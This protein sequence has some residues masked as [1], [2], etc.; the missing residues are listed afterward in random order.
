MSSDKDFNRGYSGNILHGSNYAERMGV[1]ERSLQNDRLKQEL[2]A[3]QQVFTPPA[4]PSSFNAGSSWTSARHSNYQKP[5]A[6]RQSSG[7]SWAPLG[8]IGLWV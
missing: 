3:R 6:S 1:Y 7:G 8:W 4:I 5:A 2:A